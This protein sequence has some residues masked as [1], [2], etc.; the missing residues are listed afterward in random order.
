MLDART[1]DAAVG[2]RGTFG[3]EI[4][5]VRGMV[6]SLIM[7]MGELGKVWESPGRSLCL[8]FRPVRFGRW[9]CAFGQRFEVRRLFEVLL[10]RRGEGRGFGFEVALL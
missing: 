5:G 10:L 4:W 7:S 1:S 9:F 3:I 2:G 6:G 8:L